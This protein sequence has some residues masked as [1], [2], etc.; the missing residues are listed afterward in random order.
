[1]I[2]LADT[3]VWLDHW[4]RGNP[5]F[6][7]LLGQRRVVLHPFV[8]GEIALGAIRD[9]AEVLRHLSRLRVP[10]VARH[11]EV[12]ALVERTR[13]WRR[14]VGWVDAHLIASTQLEHARLW[15]LDQPLARIAA[16]LGVAA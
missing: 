13:L 2:V 11:E 16:E 4:R 6:A 8:L 9:R 15:T 7:E 14:G 12:L 10:R 5:R 3:S 1:M